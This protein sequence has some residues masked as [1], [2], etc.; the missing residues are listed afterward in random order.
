[1]YNHIINSTKR[2]DNMKNKTKN[3]KSGKK[4]FIITSVLMSVVFLVLPSFI[5]D[6]AYYYY[7]KLK[8][9]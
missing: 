4:G 9:K 2:T 3:K 7:T 5:G 8:R 6:K 1:M